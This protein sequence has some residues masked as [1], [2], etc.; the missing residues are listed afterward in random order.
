MELKELRC[1][2]CL[3]EKISWSRETAR[4]SEMK[5]ESRASHGHQSVRPAIKAVTLYALCC[6][7]DEIGLCLRTLPSNILG[8]NSQFKVKM[9]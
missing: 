4:L 3:Y 7:K 5:A 8:V 2:S 6:G 9:E 1:A